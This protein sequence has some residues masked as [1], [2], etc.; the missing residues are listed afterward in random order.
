[1][2]FKLNMITL[3]MT[4][5][6]TPAMAANFSVGN[7]NTDAVNFS[8]YECKRCTQT[9]GYTGEVSV[10]AGYNSVDDIHAGNA[11]G[12]AEDS[13]I[14]A[15]S[16]DLHY[17]NEEGYQAKL[18]THLLGMDNGFARFSA[19][20]S[21]VYSINL[22]YDSIKTYQAGNIE[23]PF[24]HNNGMLT[25]SDTMRVLDLAQQREKI[26]LGVE[27][28]QDLLDSRF[29]ANASFSQED[30]T[31]H[32]S[33]SLVA[34]NPINFGLPVDAR[35]KQLDADINISGD[36]WLAAL[37]Y[38]GSYYENKITHISL[39]HLY[40]VQAATPDNQA[41]L[42]SLSGQYQLNHTVM[43]GRLASGRMIQDEDLI[44]VSDSPLQS[45]DGQVDT[46]DGRFAI[47]T[48][49]THR[50]RLGASFAYSDRDNHSST[51][52]FTQYNYN[53]VTGT[54]RQ[55]KP[56][57]I[58][59]HTYKL[60]ANY[61]IASGY[62]L[63]TGYDRKAVARTFTDRE[64]T[65]DDSLW[66]KLN[67]RAFD[68]FN[69]S[70]KGEHA[71]RSGSEYEAS[72]ETS[73][74]N[75]TLLRKYYLADRKRN[76]VELNINHMPNNWISVDLSTR[77]ANDD[78][79]NTQIGLTEAQDYGYNFNVNLQFSKFLSAYGFGAQQWINSNQAGSQSYGAADWQADVEDQFIH[80]GAGLNYGGLM[81][82]K[83]NLGLDYSF[84]NSISD[85]YPTGSDTGELYDDYYSYHHSTSAYAN[86][87]IDEQ[88]ALKLTY[89]YERYF[90]TDA[91]TVGVNDIPGM[92]TLGDINHNYNAHQVMLSFTY[93]LH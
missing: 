10:N 31:G 69:V 50:L 49:F 5:A 12:T 53:S 7:A 48:M 64:Q 78:Y 45:W 38:Q 42:V 15:I 70:I 1:M 35:T 54:F 62:R 79:H 33:S 86:Y 63:Q 82:D 30:K 3:A 25:V 6:A 20:K 58:T 75:N 29:I 40:D 26:G 80:L 2:S 81:Q 67:V 28:K 9:Q 43:S 89:R 83:L 41:H 21:G 36:N 57:D 61:R 59:R 77:Y 56:Q 39:P 13:T 44:T 92:I 24:W 34:P 84:S 4:L 23:S 73:S 37:A 55:N 76:A 71:N 87:A 47:S 88:M 27:L 72:K 68:K 18:Q 51:T 65:H 60:S 91:A 66:M 17:Q 90:D 46:L 8:Q 74:E 85:T 93:K 11:L 19:G 22:D 14:S 52:E 16:G 32:K